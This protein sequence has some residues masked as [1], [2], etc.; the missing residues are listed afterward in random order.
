M[1]TPLIFA[2]NNN[3]KL[4]E[5]RSILGPD[6]QVLSLADVDFHDDIPETQNTIEGNAEQ[7]ARYVFERL[8]MPCLAD[9]SGLEV[10][11]LNGEPGVRSAR[12]AGAHGNSAENI[13]LLLKKL[14]GVED[15]SARFKCVLAYIDNAGD[16]HLFEGIVNGTLL[17]ETR[18]QGGFGYDPLFVPDGHTRTFAEMAD[19]EKN[20][21]SHRANALRKFTEFLKAKA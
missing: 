4:M 12:Y 21:I 19:E 18:G 6:F 14:E 3:H 17:T 1:I 16:L 13:R 2:T 15:R 9:D 7:K 8:K 10:N 5:V 11:A 20:A